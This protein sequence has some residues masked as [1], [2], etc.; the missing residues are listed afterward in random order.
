MT[1]SSTTVLDHIITNENRHEIIPSVIDYDNTDHYP[2]MTI[3]NRN[4]TSNPSQPIFIRSFSK[5]NSSN[6]IN[7]LQLRLDNF[8][9]PMNT[10]TKNN[11]N[12][13]FDEFYFLITKTI[14]NHAP[15]KKAV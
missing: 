7:D 13:V 14:S 15:L 9:P 11:I 3:I 12:D 6:F 1:S 5:F 10:I 4:V 2:V 8:F